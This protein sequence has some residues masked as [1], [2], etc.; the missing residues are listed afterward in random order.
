VKVKRVGNTLCVVIPSKVAKT[1]K[2]D[3]DDMVTI[4]I[5][6]QVDIQDFFWLVENSKE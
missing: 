2:I 6:K 3:Q 4:E 5:Q 1:I